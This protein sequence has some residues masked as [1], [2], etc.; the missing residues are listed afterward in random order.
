MAAIAGTVGLLAL[1]GCGIAW[2]LAVTRKETIPSFGATCI[3]D[4]GVELKEAKVCNYALPTEDGREMDHQPK[5]VITLMLKNWNRDS[6]LNVE[7][8]VPVAKL[9]DGLG[10]T[11]QELHSK[12]DIGRISPIKIPPQSHGVLGRATDVL[13]FEVPV[14]GA[15]MLTLNLSASRYGGWGEIKVQIP[16]YVW[17]PTK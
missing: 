11:Y 4:I 10:N 6:I 7:S 5:L 14:A 16:K 13:V 15:Q 2:R 9:T 8:Q 3:G 1:I 17:Q 12:N